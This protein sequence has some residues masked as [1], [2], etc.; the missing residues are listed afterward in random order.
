MVRQTLQP[1]EPFCKQLKQLLLL[2]IA[3]RQVCHTICVLLLPLRTAPMSFKP[4]SFGTPQLCSI[5]FIRLR[6]AA[7]GYRRSTPGNTQTASHRQRKP[8]LLSFTDS[9]PLRASL[10][11]A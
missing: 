3:W 9:A 2:R 4:V 5:P 1:F 6:F 7:A 8:T 10:Q 11:Q